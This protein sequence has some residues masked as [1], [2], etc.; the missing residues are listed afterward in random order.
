M[1]SIIL[2]SLCLND[3]KLGKYLE[4]TNSNEISISVYVDDII[5]SSNNLQLLNKKFDELQEIAKKSNFKLNNNK[6]QKPQQ[7]IKVFNIETSNNSIHIIP[8]KN[9][10]FS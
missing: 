2:A 5:L 4:K 10:L 9:R 6:I 3:C 8:E 1:Q 7:K